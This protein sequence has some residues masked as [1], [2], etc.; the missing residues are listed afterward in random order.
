MPSPNVNPRI[1][2]LSHPQI[3]SEI[4]AF[5]IDRQGA[6]PLVPSHGMR[7]SS[8]SCAPTCH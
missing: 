3:A 7:K 2:V 6:Y 4:D 8:V 5:L 1:R